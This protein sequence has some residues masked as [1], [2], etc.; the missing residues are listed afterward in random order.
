MRSMKQKMMRSIICSGTKVRRGFG[1][2]LGRPKKENSEKFQESE[3]ERNDGD[4]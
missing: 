1:Q 3:D 4:E 2:N